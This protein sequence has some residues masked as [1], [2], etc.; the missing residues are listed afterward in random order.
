MAKIIIDGV[1]YKTL[2]KIAKIEYDYW[3]TVNKSRKEKQCFNSI[4]SCKIGILSEHAVKTHLLNNYSLDLIN[5]ECFG[6]RERSKSI[7][8]RKKPDIALETTKNTFL[9]E[10]K[11]ITKG[12]PKGQILIDHAQKY[13]DYKFTHVIFCEVEYKKDGEGKE[14][15]E[16]DIYLTDK[17]KNILQYPTAKNKFGKYCYTYPEYIHMVKSH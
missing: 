10:I 17:I 9:M 14:F 3:E 8:H 11:G 2:L 7:H 4:N 15:C 12:Q 13:N 1:H 16:V 6:I 5:L